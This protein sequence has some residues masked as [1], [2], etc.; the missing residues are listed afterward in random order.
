MLK[1]KPKVSTGEQFKKP[2]EEEFIKTI[3]EEGLQ[4]LVE[5]FPELEMSF[6]S[7]GK[8]LY[9]L[10]AVLQKFNIYTRDD[11]LAA[12]IS[13]NAIKKI[14]ESFSN[15][16]LINGLNESLEKSK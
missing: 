4:K 9:G 6:H 8:F 3:N 1:E 5:K 12:G 14:E 2:T 11:M 10:K 15:N 7:N 13:E 16:P